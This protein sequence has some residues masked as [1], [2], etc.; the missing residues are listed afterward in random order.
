ML[1]VNKFI[2][3]LLLIVYK[4]TRAEQR[5]TSANPKNVKILNNQFTFPI[6]TGEVDPE[7]LLSF[8]SKTISVPEFE[9][10]IRQH[11]LDE[12]KVS[13]VVCSCLFCDHYQSVLLVNELFSYVSFI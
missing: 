8:K 4:A 13:M 6:D 11:N 3:W 12:F 1:F 7:Y 9:E 5:Q 2:C 10:F